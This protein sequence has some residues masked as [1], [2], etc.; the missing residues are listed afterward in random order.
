M[1]KTEPKLPVLLRLDAKDQRGLEWLRDRCR[2][3]ITALKRRRKYAVQRG[4][5]Y[6]PEEQ[7]VLQA[8]VSLETASRCLLE[9]AGEGHRHSRR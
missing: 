2:F 3:W 7:E 8:L 5:A 6:E 4:A 9:M 1:T